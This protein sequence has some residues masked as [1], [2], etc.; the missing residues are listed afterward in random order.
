MWR[1]YLKVGLRALTK[2]KTYA[3]I[4]IFGLALGL[5]ACLILLVY[6]RYETSYDEWLPDSHRVFQVQTISL[7]PDDAESPTQQYTHGVMTETLPRDFPQIEAVA[8]RGEG[9]AGV[10]R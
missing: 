2:N 10:P 1:N 6:I 3:F 4:N 9:K 8:R 7:D 5:A